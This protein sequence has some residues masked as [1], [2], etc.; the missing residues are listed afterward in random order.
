[1]AKAEWKLFQD[2]VAEMEPLLNRAGAQIESPA[3]IPDKDTGEPREVDVLVRLPYAHQPVTIT[4]ECRKHKARQD[5]RWI[6]QLAQKR[7]SVGADRTVAVSQS[8]FTEPAKRKAAQLG[9]ELRTFSELDA[10]ELLG[11]A[12]SLVFYF[13][14]RN[15][16]NLRMEVECGPILDHPGIPLPPLPGE[17]RDVLE[18]QDLE[19]PVFLD[20]R[21]GEKRSLWDIWKTA[22]WDPVF[23]GLAPGDPAQQR[24]LD[25]RLPDNPAPF[26]TESDPP[27]YLWSMRV[28]ADFSVERV[29]L[30]P[31]ASYEYRDQKGTLLRRLE[32]DLEPVGQP[33]TA[34]IDVYPPEADGGMPIVPRFRQT[35]GRSVGLRL[36]LEHDQQ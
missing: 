27:V 15:S 14:K 32:W 12:Y 11:E 20:V 18:R 25:V 9:I 6:E 31:C 10:D 35:T 1:M 16:E 28:T 3:W 29:N 8:P 33:G 5:V 21:S 7:A 23:E 22:L 2:R 26:R 34:I 36:R 24:T 17:L 30:E 13:E 19:R 4:I